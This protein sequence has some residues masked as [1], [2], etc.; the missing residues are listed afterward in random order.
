[1]VAVMLIPIPIGLVIAW[2]IYRVLDR[3]WST[4]TFASAGP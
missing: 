3:L 2:A 4:R 1:L